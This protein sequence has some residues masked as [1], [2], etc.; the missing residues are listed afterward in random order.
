M[1]IKLNLTSSDIL[2][3]QFKFVAS[4][5]DPLKVDEFLDRIILDYEKIEKNVLLSQQEIDRLIKQNEQLKKEN[6]T[7]AIDNARYE[8]LKNSIGDNKNLLNKDNIDLIARINALEKYLY[9]HGVNPM[10]I[11]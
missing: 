5:Y 8:K 3:K 7:L 1:A 6:E 4:G 10:N 2:N 9:N 11:K